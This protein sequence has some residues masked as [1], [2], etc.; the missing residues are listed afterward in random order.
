ME[1]LELFAAGLV[2]FLFVKLVDESRGGPFALVNRD[3]FFEG[4]PA[5][6]SNFADEFPDGGV[7]DVAKRHLR[8]RA[9]AKS[10]HVLKHVFH[11]A[12]FIRVDRGGAQLQRFRAGRVKGATRE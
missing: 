3:N 5:S 12:A 7:H 9:A 4:N 6:L 10:P 11:G 2:V 8:V 1:S